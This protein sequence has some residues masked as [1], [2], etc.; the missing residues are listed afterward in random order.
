MSGGFP[1]FRAVTCSCCFAWRLHRGRRLEAQVCVCVCEEDR[2]VLGMTRPY[3]CTHMPHC[4]CVR[5]C[6]CVCVRL[7]CVFPLRPPAIPVPLPAAEAGG[8]QRV[9][10]AL[11]AA[12]LHSGACGRR[13][14]HHSGGED[15]SIRNTSLDGER[16]P[17]PKSLPGSLRS[18]IL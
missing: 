11:L 15:S 17:Q 10:A 13:R 8:V 18:V 16:H 12:R 1:S 9:A 3:E 14:A 4:T 6:V 7:R 5:L 2:V